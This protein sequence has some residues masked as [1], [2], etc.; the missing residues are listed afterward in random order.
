VNLNVTDLYAL[1]TTQPL[2][3]ERAY[4]FDSMENQRYA[5]VRRENLILKQTK[6]TLG[7]IGT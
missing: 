4:S 2:F 1:K 3:S 6:G 7:I 5:K